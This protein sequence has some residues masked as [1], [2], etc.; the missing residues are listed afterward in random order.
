MSDGTADARG[1]WPT[2][3]LTATPTRPT[4]SGSEREVVFTADDGQHGREVWLSDGT[5]GGT[6]LLLDF[7]PGPGGSQPSGFVVLDRER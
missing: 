7:H 5:E 1:A 2:S 3:R 6:R 4:S